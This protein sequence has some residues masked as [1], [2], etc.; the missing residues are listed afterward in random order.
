MRFLHAHVGMIVV[1][2]WRSPIAVALLSLVAQTALAADDEV[3][4]GPMNVLFIVADDLNNHL[5]CYGYDVKTPSIDELARRGMRF[6]RA[7]CQ[8]P[9][10]NPSRVS[11]LSGLRPDRTQ[12]YT[13]LTH[14]RAH[15]GDWVMLPEYFRKNGYFT[16]QVGKIYHTDD[17]FE[18]PRSWDVEIREFG[19]RPAL[20][21]II[22]WG[23]PHGPGG[24]TIDWEWLK[25]PDEETPDGI[26][27]RK[28]VR[29]MEQAEAEKKPFFL[30]VGF[31]R[32]HAPFAAP[33][34]Y[35]ELYPPESIELADPPASDHYENLLAAAINYQAPDRPLSEKEQREL[36]AAYYACNSF[37]DA[38]VGIL[39]NALDGLKLWDN[40]VV[41]FIGDHGYHLGEHGGL[42]HKMS[43]FEESVRVPMIIYA[44]G[45]KAAG[46]PCAR[47]VEFVD[48]YPTLVS[49]CGLPRREGLDGIE[50]TP[51]LNDPDQPTKE[52]AYTV[53]SR[54]KDP[55]SDHAKTADYLGRSV[56]TERWRYTEWDGGKRGAEFYD[57]E[58]DPREWKNLAAE[59]Q[60][61]D[62]VAQLRK[63][64]MVKGTP[65]AE[66]E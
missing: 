11:L 62:T 22:K 49:L 56:R 46:E 20:D 50:L 47:I 37:V 7:Y 33:R 2:L 64:L 38:Q 27:A 10:C 13:L 52:A 3:R 45:M 9:V 4:G 51:V 55:A 5:G 30:G 60:F 25:T 44:P 39:L 26:V 29:Y 66:S 35:F 53:V 41:V 24:H 8:N 16:V 40:T 58:N 36:V 18:D 54:S 43:L 42:W 14:T 12:V 17:G 61:A 57:H 63:L 6:D 59:P 65:A 15:L 34:K 1:L 21:Q 19:K 48:I 28:A 32:P 31:R 23:E